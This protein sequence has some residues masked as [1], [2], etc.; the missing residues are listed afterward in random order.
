MRRFWFGKKSLWN[1]STSENAHRLVSMRFTISNEKLTNR[2]TVIRLL[3]SCSAK[4]WHNRKKATQCQRWSKGT[5]AVALPIYTLLCAD[6]IYQYKKKAF[7]ALFKGRQSDNAKNAINTN[8]TRNISYL[9]PTLFSLFMQLCVA[10]E[11]RRT[12]AK[13]IHHIVIAECDEFAQLCTKNKHIV[14]HFISHFLVKWR[15]S[16]LEKPTTLQP[17]LKMYAI[18]VANK[19]RVDCCAA[20]AASFHRYCCFIWVILL[21]YSRCQVKY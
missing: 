18:D 1:G 15:F 10:Y 5:N 19:I 13:R 2:F 16:F 17:P 11:K 21:F 8:K 9:C 6:V 12:R 20:S 3:C 14:L 7:Y 4:A